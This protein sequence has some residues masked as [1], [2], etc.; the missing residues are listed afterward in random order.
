MGIVKINDQLHEDIR[1]ASAVMVRSIN[2]QAEYWIKIGML[3]EANPTMTFS[4]I[5]REQMK[6]ADVDVRKVVGA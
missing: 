1:K 5:M 4:E 2:A 3:A 6:Q